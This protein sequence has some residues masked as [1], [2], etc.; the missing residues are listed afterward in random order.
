MKIAMLGSLGNVNRVAVPELLNAGH[1]V[2]LLTSSADRV[3]EIEALGAHAVVG[4]MTNL[5]DLVATL[6]GVPH[7]DWSCHR[8]PS[9]SRG[10]GR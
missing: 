8:Q 2:T 10:N 9:R 4:S 1:E 7:V 6:R 3:A 5:D